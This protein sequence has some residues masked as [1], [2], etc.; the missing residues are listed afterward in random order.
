[1]GQYYMMFI[2]TW[3][4]IELKIYYKTDIKLYNVLNKVKD[5]YN[6]QI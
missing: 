2:N 6:T 1:M 4:F 5:K 3:L